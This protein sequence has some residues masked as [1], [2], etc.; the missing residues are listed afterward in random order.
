[1]IYLLLDQV[2]W[3]GIAARKS[4]QRVRDQ[5]FMTWQEHANAR[6]VKSFGKSQ[7]SRA[8]FVLRCKAN[9]LLLLYLQNTTNHLRLEFGLQEYKPT[10]LTS[11]KAGSSVWAAGMIGLRKFGNTNSKERAMAKIAAKIALVTICM[12]A[13]SVLAPQAKA[14]DPS[15]LMDFGCTPCSGT[16]T[17]GA[18]GTAPFVGSGI[19]LTLSAATNPGSPSLVGD[20]FALAF[21]TSTGAISLTEVTGSGSFDLSG[22][23]TSF[24]CT[25]VGTED[26]CAVGATMTGLGSATDPGSI[27]FS[28]QT[29]AF[30]TAGSV[31]NADLSVVTPEPASMLLMGTGLVSLG[32]LLRRRR[33]V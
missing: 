28:F 19:D 13:L 27:A 5:W 16:V 30:G 20:E 6:N 17:F 11:R 25:A 23:I 2:F 29:S 32:G 14:Q 33:K 12:L 1:M 8:L 10:Y 18:G 26:V 3:K 9:L 4:R 31:E 21:N 24:S 7:V 15:G 22:T